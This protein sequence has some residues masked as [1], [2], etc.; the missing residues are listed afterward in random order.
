MRGPNNVVFMNY[1]DAVIGYYDNLMKHIVSPD[2]IHKITFGHF[3]KPNEDIKDGHTYQRTIDLLYLARLNR[4]KGFNR[5]MDHANYLHEN[6]NVL[7][8]YAMYG[9]SG[10]IGQVAYKKM[11]EMIVDIGKEPQKNSDDAYIWFRSAVSDRQQVVDILKSSRFSWNAWSFAARGKDLYHVIDS[12]LE[13]AP[14]EAIRYGCVPILNDI[15]KDVEVPISTNDMSKTMK[16]SEFNCAIFTNDNQSPEELKS[17]L[18]DEISTRH[19]FNNCNAF[20]SIMDCDLLYHNTIIATFEKIIASSHNRSK[21]PCSRV[22]E[23]C[24]QKELMEKGKIR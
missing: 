24:N 12:G 14:L 5:Y 17:L 15:H 8:S 10:N 21:A 6:S 1:C 20:K 11:P 9:F 13:A 7:T 22:D 2:K 4:V 3:Y 23:F 18:E 16:L 19:K